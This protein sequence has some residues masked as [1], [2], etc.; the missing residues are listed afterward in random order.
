MEWVGWVGSILLMLCAVP[1]VIRSV[2]RKQCDIGW[3]ML[4]SWLFGEILVLIYV[5]PKKD[6]PL[7]ANY[8]GNT[9]LILILCYY[10]KYGQSIQK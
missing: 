5:I 3:G 1:E 10:R 2:I 7:I 6:I 8:L 9:I 4:L